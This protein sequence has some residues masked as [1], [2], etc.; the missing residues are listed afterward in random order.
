MWGLLVL[1]SFDAFQILKI[2]NVLQNIALGFSALHALY[3][4]RAL[5]PRDLRPSLI[6]QLGVFACGVFFLGISAI[7][8]VYLYL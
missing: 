4:N 1:S 5:M 6:L 7:V 2:S 8:F 3:V